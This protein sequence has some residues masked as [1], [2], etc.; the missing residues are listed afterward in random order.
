[1]KVGFIL[2]MKNQQ[3][4]TEESM[5][6]H[7]PIFLTACR[8]TNSSVC[9]VKYIVPMT[10]LDSPIGAMEARAASDGCSDLP[11]K[12]SWAFFK[13][14]STSD[15][16]GRE[17]EWHQSVW[18]NNRIPN[19]SEVSNPRYKRFRLAFR[20]IRI[21]EVNSFYVCWFYV[22]LFVDFLKLWLTW[23]YL[24]FVKRPGIMFWLKAV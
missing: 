10:S 17:P 15:K 22:C 16:S 21:L 20:W 2:D 4:M 18:N 14:E 13:C 24:C 7:P 5:W 1:M 3:E 8:K 23:F 19:L 9:P 11:E 6:N 12:S